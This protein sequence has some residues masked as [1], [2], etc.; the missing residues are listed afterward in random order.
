M[1][2]IFIMS[3]SHCI[4]FRASAVGVGYRGLNRLLMHNPPCATFRAVLS[5]SIPPDVRKKL[6]TGIL[7]LRPQE[8]IA[9]LEADL[10]VTGEVIVVMFDLETLYL[11]KPVM[12]NGFL[13]SDSDR[14]NEKLL[15]SATTVFSG[16]RSGG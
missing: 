4:L 16:R 10:L 13:L 9:D 11:F 8:G 1:L 14:P 3:T 7:A 6:C 5:Q 12:L 2:G 15:A